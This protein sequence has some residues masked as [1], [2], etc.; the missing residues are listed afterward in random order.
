[1]LMVLA[2]ACGGSHDD[3]PRASQPTGLSIL[4]SEALLQEAPP[5]SR[6]LSSTAI[7]DC[8]GDSHT[9]PSVARAYAFTSDPP[10]DVAE[11][12]TA[13]APSRGWRRTE[14]YGVSG[15]KNPDATSTV[16]AKSR[17]VNGVRVELTME[18]RTV[19]EGEQDFEVL[20]YA[21]A[22]HSCGTG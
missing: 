10:P 9:G 6:L 21:D 17:I 18:V 2:S 3:H 8:G 4:K 14:S 13:E 12:F 20:G 11:F 15:A 7:P 5:N 1:M 16:F 19:T 22:N